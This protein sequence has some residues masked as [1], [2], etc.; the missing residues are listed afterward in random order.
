MINSIIVRH[1]PQP[2]PRGEMLYWD[3]TIK[4]LSMKDIFPEKFI[5][6]SSCIHV[7]GRNPNCYPPQRVFS[8]TVIAKFQEQRANLQSDEARK[9]V[10]NL[11]ASIKQEDP[12]KTGSQSSEST[13][14]SSKTERKGNE[15]DG[16]ALSQ[17]YSTLSPSTQDSSSLI[18]LQAEGT[19]FKQSHSKNDPNLNP[20]NLMLTFHPQSSV[21]K[22]LLEL[23]SKIH[24][25]GSLEVTQAKIFKEKVRNIT[26][27]VLDN[28][29]ENFQLALEVSDLDGNKLLAMNSDPFKY[30]EKLFHNMDKNLLEYFTTKKQLAM[31]KEL[32][33]AQ[34]AALRKLNASG[35]AKFRLKEA[36]KEMVWQQIQ[37]EYDW[38]EEFFQGV[39]DSE[40]FYNYIFTSFIT[41]KTKKFLS[42][43]KKVQKLLNLMKENEQQLVSNDNLTFEE[44]IKPYLAKADLGL[45]SILGSTAE[46]VFVKQLEKHWGRLKEDEKDL[47][48]LIEYSVVGANIHKAL[49]MIIN[50]Q[51]AWRMVK[52]LIIT[53]LVRLQMKSD[54]VKENDNAAVGEDAVLEEDGYGGESNKLIKKVKMEM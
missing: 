17:I 3:T 37:Q 48:N 28:D 54:E 18:T 41:N 30:K 31:R 46:S 39:I 50:R 26:V 23:L 34:L 25:E 9:S 2:G 43:T 32:N 36:K 11:C 20:S 4:I 45:S 47:E 40:G 5:P 13:A 1:N 22:H 42:Q 16:S 14:N 53:R 38:I 12:I 24:I 29:L 33:K 7:I 15:T 49:W 21:A 51:E 19:L 52:K 27:C 6:L 44:K 8:E 35:C 10:I